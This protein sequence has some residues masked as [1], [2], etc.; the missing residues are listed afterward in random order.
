M[1]QG[2]VPGPLFMKNY[3]PMLYALF[4]I[5][6]ISSLFLFLVG[7]IFL[8]LARKLTSIP[9]DILYPTVIF[10][11]VIG[12]YVFQNS[13]FDVKIMLF[14]GLL[15]YVFTKLDI[16]IPPILIAFILGGIFERKIRQTFLISGG[17]VNIF[18][19]RPI[20]LLLLMLTIVVIII[21]GLR[22]KLPQVEY[23]Q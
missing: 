9:K 5:L 20:T 15:G 1:I 2:L 13:L 3:A 22:K 6:I 19:T 4:I 8:K 14:L 11:G 16:P 10:F 7:S 23:R 21:F 12:S 18:F 17:S